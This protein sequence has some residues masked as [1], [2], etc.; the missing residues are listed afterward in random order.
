MAL[1]VKKVKMDKKD[2]NKWFLTAYE[3]LL[4]LG[5]R[6]RDVEI[7]FGIDRN[8][9]KVMKDINWSKAHQRAMDRLEVRLAAKGIQQAVGYDYEETKTTYALDRNEKADCWKA[10]KKETT[11]KHQSGNPTMFMFIMT[12]KFGENWKNSK[13]LVTR[14]ENYDSDPAERNRKRIVSLARDVLEA[15]TE[16]PKEKRQLPAE[17]PRIPNDWDEGS[18]EH[19]CGDMQGE[20][21]G[22]IQDNVLDVPA[23]G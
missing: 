2:P 1:K 13:E 20:A 16:K 18:P 5:M 7:L 14:K 9:K 8:D 6:Q 12:N 4:E 22:N 21:V 3:S 15:N 23:E 19:V 11:R 10:T 17:S